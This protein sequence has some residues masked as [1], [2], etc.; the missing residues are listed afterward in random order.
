MKI[1]EKT[2][3]VIQ[4]G[5][6]PIPNDKHSKQPKKGQGT[7]LLMVEKSLNRPKPPCL[8]SRAACPNHRDLCVHRNSIEPAKSA[9]RPF[10]DACVL[11]GF[12]QAPFFCPK[13]SCPSCPIPS[14]CPELAWSRLLPWGRNAFHKESHGILDSCRLCVSGCI[15][16]KRI[17]SCFLCLSVTYYLPSYILSICHGQA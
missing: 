13:R 7:P 4:L 10:A 14:T 8:H 1:F 5:R 6:L 9:S 3:K 11:A 16:R 12:L 2:F 17:L 15:P